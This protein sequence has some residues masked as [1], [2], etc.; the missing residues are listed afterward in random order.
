M[1]ASSRDTSNAALSVRGFEDVGPVL[2]GLSIQGYFAS[3]ERRAQ[4]SHHALP[5]WMLKSEV[6]ASTELQFVESE[7]YRRVAAL[8][9]IVL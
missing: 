8:F 3:S 6:W 2:L 7:R 4:S 5:S 9:G 1:P